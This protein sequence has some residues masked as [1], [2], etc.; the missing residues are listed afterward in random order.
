MTANANE[1]IARC[2]AELQSGDIL[3]PGVSG[4]CAGPDAFGA[5][6]VAVEDRPCT[7]ATWRYSGSRAWQFVFRDE[8]DVCPVAI[9]DPL[10][11]LPVPLD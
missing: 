4:E 10:G 9:L 6:S 1:S 8:G 2:Y 5:C 3:V 7:G 11:P